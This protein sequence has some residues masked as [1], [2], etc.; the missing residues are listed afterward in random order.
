[1]NTDKLTKLEIEVIQ[2]YKDDIEK[3]DRREYERLTAKFEN[4]PIPIIKVIIE[5]CDFYYWAYAEDEE[6]ITGAGDTVEAAKQAI[7]VA[8]G[9]KQE[10][11][12]FPNVEYKIIFI[13]PVKNPL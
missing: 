5:K 12:N 1:M 4:H 13:E 10:L 7:Y 11:G 8:M 2:E 9:I 3:K 6:G